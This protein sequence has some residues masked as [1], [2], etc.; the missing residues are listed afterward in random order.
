MLIMMKDTADSYMEECLKLMKDHYRSLGTSEK[1]VQDAANITRKFWQMMH[2]VEL[3]G[4][5]GFTIAVCCVMTMQLKNPFESKPISFE[6]AK[7]LCQ[8]VFKK[9]YKLH[10][11]KSQYGLFFS[12]EFCPVFKIKNT[13]K[14]EVIRGIIDSFPLSMNSQSANDELDRLIKLLNIYIKSGIPI[15]EESWQ[16]LEE[17]AKRGA[18]LEKVKK[19]N[20]NG[21]AAERKVKSVLPEFSEKSTEA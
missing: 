18:N 21:R 16:S 19:I 4:R 6:L 1:L 7:E 14:Q 12:S 2:N 5:G 13:S 3:A 9:E 15:R 10:Y 20:L 11:V 17:V 8:I